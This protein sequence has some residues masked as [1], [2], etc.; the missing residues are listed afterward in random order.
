MKSKI[1]RR[2]VSV[3]LVL[4]TAL[5][6]FHVPVTAEPGTGTAG[7]SA[8]NP[9]EIDSMAQLIEEMEK[10][11]TSPTYYK[12]TKDISHKTSIEYFDGRE[13]HTGDDGYNTVRKPQMAQCVVG[14]GKKF[15]ELNGYD[16]HYKNNV[17]FNL[18]DDHS[19]Y[20]GSGPKYDSLTFFY[21]GEGCDLTVSNTTGDDAEVW[22]DG[23]MH[24]RT[25]FFGGP[26]Y[27]YTAV[28]DVFR[29]EA[30]A[31]LTVNNTDIKA[32]RNRKIWMVN[33]YYTDREGETNLIAKLTYNGYAYE[34]IYGS[35]IVANGGKVTVNGGYIEGRGG[36]RD[37]FNVSGVPAW[38]KDSIA[39]M[40]WGGDFTREAMIENCLSNVGAKAAVQIAGEGSTVIINDGEFWGCGGANVIG[41]NGLNDGSV[42]E[43]TLRINAGTF[44]TSK[45]DKER[46]PDRCAGVVNSGPWPWSH[47][48]WMLWA[49]CRCIRDTLRGYIG[50]PAV[51]GYGN[52]VFNT[53][54]V[55]VYIDDEE[56][57]D[58]CIDNADLDFRYKSD[59]DTIIVKPREGKAYDN[60]DTHTRVDYNNR[61]HY[62]IYAYL[63]GKIVADTEASGNTLYY[64][65]TVNPT[66]Y[67]SAE[68][69]YDLTDADNPY[70]D[71]GHFVN[72]QWTLY[73]EDENGDWI[74]TYQR[75][76]SPF[77]TEHRDGHTIYNFKISMSSFTGFSDV[78]MDED[79]TYYMVA[80]MEEFFHGK[81]GSDYHRTLS[82]TTGV[83]QDW[84][85]GIYDGDGVLDFYYNMGLEIV[86][87]Q[88]LAT[89]GAEVV[90]SNAVYGSD[91]VLTF[92]DAFNEMKVNGT[93]VYQWQVLEG[94]TWVDHG[95]YR[96][97]PELAVEVLLKHQGLTGKQVRLKITPEYCDELPIYSNICTVQKDQNTRWPT[98]GVFSWEE[99]PVNSGKYITKTTSYNDALEWLIYPYDSDR[100]LSTLNWSNAV[101]VPE[102]NNLEIGVYTVYARFKETVDYEAGTEIGYS[103]V[104]VGNYVEP[105]G[106]N[107]LYNG[108]PVTE[109]FVK[110]YEEFE[111]TVAPLPDN[112]T[113]N[114]TNVTRWINES[115]KTEI[116]MLNN[117]STPD[118]FEDFVLGRTVKFVSAELGYVTFKAVT[119]LGEEPNSVETITVRVVPDEYIPYKVSIVNRGAEV[120]EGGSFVPQVALHARV[121]MLT[122]RRATEFEVEDLSVDELKAQLQSDTIKQQLR[123]NL[124]WALVNPI[125][126]LDE[127]PYVE[128]TTK[129][130]INTK[131]GE[132]TLKDAAVA[133]NVINFVGKLNDPYLGQ[134][135]IPGSIT[136]VAAPAAHP[137]NYEG[138]AKILGDS[139]NHFR[140]CECGNK[141]TEAHIFTN[142]TVEY[143]GTTITLQNVCPCGYTEDGEV[144]VPQKTYII[145]PEY[146][147]DDH[148]HWK[149]CTNED[150]TEKHEKSPH[151]FTTVTD[152]NSGKEAKVCSTC[153][154]I[155]I[156]PLVTLSGKVNS[157]GSET[158]SVTLQLIAAGKTTP[159]YEVVVTGNSADY[160]IDIF[161]AGTYT[162]RISKAKHVSREYTVV[163]G[164]DG[165]VSITT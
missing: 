104:V 84:E 130:S 146:I 136:V 30:G 106:T 160:S 28:R 82:Y 87:G 26:N 76:T 122:E 66:L 158:D 64:G 101:D 126:Q 161:T 93:E 59:S 112:A 83:F 153:N 123:D 117:S 44:D 148:D 152:T 54:M 51:D 109:I 100:D 116:I 142:F 4:S 88:S 105:T 22:Y 31:E 125:I 42:K 150:C 86:Y 43:Y 165:S 17:N 111:L 143:E 133:G 55:H 131:T 62:E 163:I 61:N 103:K 69:H 92:N 23:W 108:K 35:A 157:F 40:V 79:H 1:L 110:Q 156:K 25:N 85:D 32:G 102:F 10:D 155:A 63:D 71:R 12:L 36:Y 60:F 34:Q 115:G 46:V 72:C 114:S 95:N 57:E 164:E 99:N 16:I 118:P 162:F 39:D 38:N 90:Y 77:K 132:I 15:L 48:N 6:T 18:G 50:I 7:E 78:T 65:S 94:D 24:N 127:L 68:S 52:N 13:D 91:P 33:S 129:A 159:D 29:V 45:T 3:L 11:V 147:Y 27:I 70:F 47:S 2:I 120:E 144:I 151:V 89:C 135:I 97:S 137:C 75:V 53:K 96:S 128:S 140:V 141:I 145:L 107:V 8:E 74:N 49:N 41:I 121:A 73:E 14:T 56:P 154:Y 37:S 134:I 20:W 139:E 81:L 98:I 58:E 19:K 9:I 21:L 119:T 149:L 5:A 80:K 113:L 67:F 124:T 138:Y